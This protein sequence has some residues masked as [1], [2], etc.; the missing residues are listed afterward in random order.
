MDRRRFLLTA[1]AG[2]LA[3]PLV[4]DAQ[5][6]GK[7]YRIGVLADVSV[8]V[9]FRA[10]ERRL[11]ELGYLP[12]TNL[13][14]D[15]REAVGR[16]DRLPVL[17]AELLRLKPDLII[18]AGGVEVA[19]ALK[20]ATT[21]VPVVFSAVE[22]DP[23]ATGIVASLV[24][25]GGNITGPALLSTEITTKR[26]ELLREALP[27]A[28]RVAVLWQ[29]I[30]AEDQLNTVLRAAKS[31]K[32]HIIALEIR[33]IPSDLDAAVKMAA[34]QRADALMILGT[35][36]FYPERKRLADLALTHR[37]PASFQRS[38]YVEAGGLMAYGA[39]IEEM[40]R[41]VAVYA[42]RI[43]KG[44]RPADLPIE[45]AAKFELV[46]NLKT[47]RALGLTIPPSLLARANQVIE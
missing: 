39:D 20:Q 6:S 43:L 36:S 12:G 15:V 32:I 40:W 9:S 4:A 1:L 8:P 26:L 38:A 34:Q 45:Q 19:R 2:A 31:L 25:P 30:R 17:A 22:W 3:G 24:R 16:G 5:Q 27:R 11:M 37:L 21:T 14:L 41:R 47:A 29:R 35:P 10:F 7:I 23:V 46:I 18:A 28:T 13:V 44:T 42:D 33:E